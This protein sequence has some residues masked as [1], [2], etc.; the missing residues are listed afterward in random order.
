MAAYEKAVALDPGE[1]DGWRYLG[2]LQYRVGSLD[3]AQDAFVS[4][5]RVAVLSANLRAQA[6]ARMRLG[7]I[8]L[9]RNETPAAETAFKEG[10]SLSEQS[11]WSEGAARAYGN[12]SVVYE[13]QNDLLKAED[14][15]NQALELYLQQDDKPGIARAY[16]NLGSINEERSDPSKAE[17]MFLKGTPALRRDR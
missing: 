15:A 10:L 4:M 6:M 8:L 2:E 5:D 17:E 13:R 1:P 11:K 7:W 16:G 9:D 3:L 12:L 14:A